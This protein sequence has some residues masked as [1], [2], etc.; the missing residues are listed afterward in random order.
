MILRHPS[1]RTTPSLPPKAYPQKPTPKSTPPSREGGWRSRDV[2]MSSAAA[3]ASDGLELDRQSDPTDVLVAAAVGIAAEQDDRGREVEAVG[4]RDAHA[5]LA[6]EEAGAGSDSGP[7]GRARGDDARQC[8]DRR[9]A[10]PL[11]TLHGVQLTDVDGVGA[12][13]AGS[14]VGDAPFGT[15]SAG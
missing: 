4:N 5:R 6:A 1:G 11:F 3:S 2:S 10:T 12:E 9:N 15:G 14:D 8:R 7:A 13:D